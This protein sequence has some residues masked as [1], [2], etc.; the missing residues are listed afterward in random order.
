MTL[1]SLG[2]PTKKPTAQKES[3]SES[4]RNKPTFKADERK[5]AP[6][7]SRI[8]KRPQNN[9]NESER[10]SVEDHSRNK[11]PPTLK[12]K[13]TPIRFDI[14][15]ATES[16]ELEPEKKRR[17]KSSDRK[18]VDKERERKSTD[19]DDNRKRDS[20]SDERDAGESN[21][22]IRTLKSSSQNKYDNL[23]PRKYYLCSSFFTWKFFAVNIQST[24]FFATPV[25][26]A[27]TVT[28]EIKLTKKERCKFYPVCTR[29]DRCDYY[30]PT[31]P[32]KAFPN[33]KYGDIC[34]YIH[35]KCKFD[36]TCSRLDCNFTHTPVASAAPPLG[37]ALSFYFF[38]KFELYV[39]LLTPYIW[40][41]ST[42]SHVVPVSNYKKIV[43]TPLP[44]L[45]RFY[46]NC[47]NTL[48]E[49]YH[50]KPCKF[51]KNCTNKVECNFYHFDLPVPTP[52]S[53]QS[54]PMKNKL[55]WV[56]SAV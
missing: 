33:C 40:F 6:I 3:I 37:N 30:H 35:P 16:K 38:S 28:S 47:S 39:T 10:K 27:I 22:K 24:E 31:T 48:C 11:S 49:F 32:C 55:K 20:R 14:N 1:D 9:Q 29:G 41:F 5:K 34:L 51:G 52:P 12:R 43:T 26:S 8:G 19:R 2:F 7:I 13:R 18:S 25:S 42:A 45:C 36:L 53:H 23:P 56:A 54:M 46:P 17:S 4:K 15:D 44:T 21:S 50:P